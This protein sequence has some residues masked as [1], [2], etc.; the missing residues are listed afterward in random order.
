[1]AVRRALVTAASGIGD[2]LRVTPLIRVCALLGFEV[3]VLIAPD[4]P[5]TATLL[6]GAPEIR[7]LYCRPSRWNGQSASGG[8]ALPTESYDV[9]TFTYWSSSLRT[10]VRAKNMLWFEPR[11]WLSEGDSRCVARL[12]KELGWNAAIPAPF[13]MKSKRR[14]GVKQETVA[15]HPGCKP[16][17][18]WKKWHGFDQLA[19]ELPEVLVLGTPSD[20]DN[21]KTY[22]QKPYA[23][24]DHALNFS[25]KLSLLEVAAVI[26]ECRALVANDSGIMHLGVALGV[27]TFGIFGITSPVRELIP[28][29]NMFPVSKGL[30]CEPACHRGRWGRRDCEFHLQCLKTLTAGEVLEKMRERVD[31]GLMAAG[32]EGKR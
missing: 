30:P 2:V 15:I 10:Q 29:P 7:Q 14:F 3:D 32:L 19:R 24:P 8:D 22:F 16:D 6:A 25:E 20:F 1:M 31:L 28:A 18:P 27:P 17:W 13:A 5:D 11:K 4:Y 12:A 9:A 23:W 21:S 26:A